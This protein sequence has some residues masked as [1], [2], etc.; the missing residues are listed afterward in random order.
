MHSANPGLPTAT[1]QAGV[2]PIK[3]VVNCRRLGGR[4]TPIADAATKMFQNG[5]TSCGLCADDNG[6]QFPCNPKK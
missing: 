1:R 3:T 5:N 4:E 2:T 6:G